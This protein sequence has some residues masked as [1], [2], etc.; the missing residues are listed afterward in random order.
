M[1]VSANI[2]SRVLGLAAG[3]LLGDAL[4]APF[5]GVKG[6]HVRQLA[7]GPVESFLENSVLFPEKPDRNWLPG[8][9]TCRGQEF[10][11]VL[12]GPAAGET[13]QHPLARAAANLR[14]LAGD[15]EPAAGAVNRRALRQPGRPLRRAL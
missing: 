4:G 9:H 3:G 10:L 5:N 8:L 1:A 2:S 15:A 11:A 12:A 14:E 7:G 13:G 6:G